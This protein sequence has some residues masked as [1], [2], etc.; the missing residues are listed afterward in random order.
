MAMNEFK[1]P[2]L[3]EG[4]SEAEIVDWHVAPGDRVVENQPLVSVETEK[5]VVEIPA[6]YSGVVS[7]IVVPIGEF[8]PVGG[9]LLRFETGPKPDEGTVVGAIEDDTGSENRSVEAE[10][11]ENH[12]TTIRSSTPVKAT[13]HARKLAEQHNINLTDLSGTGPE[14]AITREDVK[15]VL[16]GSNESGVGEKL[17]G[18]RRTMARAMASSGSQ[19]VPATLM[20]KIDISLWTDHDDTTPRLVRAMGRACLK[21]PALN[22][23]FEA[24]NERR[25]L[26]SKVN[27]GLAV[28][29]DD[30]LIV[31]VLC[32]V[33]EQDISTLRKA[34]D[35]L[36]RAAHARSLARSQLQGQTISLSNFGM[37]GGLYAN[38]VVVPP[39]VAIL[40]AGRIHAALIPSDQ[41]PATVTHLPLSLTFDHR[42]VTGAEAAQFM[43]A[44]LEDL[45]HAR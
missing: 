29:T 16:K 44:I 43:N 17:R 2:D 15:A 30:G 27:I 9:V 8:V 1:L 6:P 14:G 41:G 20:E 45:A 4:L 18:V 7:E 13:P 37:I 22:A 33:N 31:P 12:A 3:G 25:I 24:Q 38:L 5:A 19:V 35:Y 42:A 28:D 11:D 21:Q 26:H 23:W 40:G 34:I 10:Q 36:V 32:D 39:Q